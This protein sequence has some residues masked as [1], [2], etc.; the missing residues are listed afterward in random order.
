MTQ[1]LLKL[2]NPTNLAEAE[3]IYKKYYPDAGSPEQEGLTQLIIEYNE[4]A[5][6]ANKMEHYLFTHEIP[7]SDS[8]TDF[9]SYIEYNKKTYEKN[10][11][12]AKEREAHRR[13]LLTLSPIDR[14]CEKSGFKKDSIEYKTANY[15]Y[16][17]N[18]FPYFCGFWDIP[19][20]AF[21]E[22]LTE[23]SNS[24]LLSYKKNKIEDFLNSNPICLKFRIGVCN[25]G[26][27][28]LT[29]IVGACSE[30][31]KQTKS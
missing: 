5:E 4:I 13:Y 17:S 26:E 21:E 12:M 14:F 15:F 25:D 11:K 16:N 24:I 18:T 9:E 3:T 8:Y 29:T 28:V 7:C 6:F 31:Y 19:I 27:R 1:K 10:A 22:I 30:F 23:F 2:F 20:S